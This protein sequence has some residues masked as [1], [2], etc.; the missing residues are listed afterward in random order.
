VMTPSEVGKLLN[1]HPK[2]VVALIKKGDIPGEKIGSRW[3][4]HR[5]WFEAWQRGEMPATRKD[6]A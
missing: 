5:P 4:I 2:T 6:A 3:V 1:K